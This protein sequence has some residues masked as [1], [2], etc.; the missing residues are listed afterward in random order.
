MAWPGLAW[1]PLSLVCYLAPKSYYAQGNSPYV[2]DQRVELGGQWYQVWGSG[3][4][5][6]SLACFLAMLSLSLV[7]THW[8]FSDLR[9]MVKEGGS[10]FG[11]IQWPSGHT[12]MGLQG[13]L[14]IGDPDFSRHPPG[15]ALLVSFSHLCGDIMDLSILFILRWSNPGWLGQHKRIHRRLLQLGAG[16]FGIA[17]L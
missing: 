9:T 8:L 3:D 15:L 12:R 7:V 13:G 11:Q 14:V 4:L 5:P 17:C 16:H 6:N 1:D 2:K 10:R